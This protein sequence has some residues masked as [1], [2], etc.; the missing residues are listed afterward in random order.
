MIKKLIAA[1]MAALTVITMAGCAGKKPAREYTAQELKEAIMASRDKESNEGLP[2]ATSDDTEENGMLFEFM[3]LPAE[4][5]KTYAMSVSLM[6]VHAYAVGVLVPAEGKQ[7][8]VLK[9]VNS[10]V[11]G[12]QKS[13]ESYLPNQYEITKKAIVKTQEDGS[14]ILVMCEDSQTVYDNIVKALAKK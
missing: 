2:F 11:E 12:M 3:Q 7:E 10:Y 13:F 14:I 4:D 1:A 6:N 5:I 9:A 8:A